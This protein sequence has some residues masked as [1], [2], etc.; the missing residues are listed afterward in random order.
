MMRTAILKPMLAGSIL[1]LAACGDSGEGAGG[2]SA[3][4]SSQLNEAAA[5]LDSAP[6]TLPT[7]DET[8]LGN[9]EGAEPAADPTAGQTR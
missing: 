8:N 7:S 1:L 6:D 2:V 3:K 5:M 9:D 4:E